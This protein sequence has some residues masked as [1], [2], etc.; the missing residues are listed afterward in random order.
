MTNEQDEKGDKYTNG[1]VTVRARARSRRTR[2]V[3]VLGADVCNSV[4]NRR[5]MG[6]RSIAG[7]DQAAMRGKQPVARECFYR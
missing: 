5:R 2:W 4:Q 3:S 6:K 1:V 7:S